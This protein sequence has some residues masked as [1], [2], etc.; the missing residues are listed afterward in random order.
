M[1]QVTFRRAAL[2]IIV[3]VPAVLVAAAMW[4]VVGYAIAMG[5]FSAATAVAMWRSRG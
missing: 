5:A 3:W 1:A 2:W 4:G